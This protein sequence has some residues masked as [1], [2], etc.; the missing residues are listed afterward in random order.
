LIKK[1]KNKNKLTIKKQKHET[2]SFNFISMFF[3]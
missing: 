2:Y 1:E 3:Y